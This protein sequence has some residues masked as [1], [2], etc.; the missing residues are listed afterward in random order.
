MLDIPNSQNPYV[1]K[2]LLLYFTTTLNAVHFSTKIYIYTFQSAYIYWRENL[3]LS[4]ILTMFNLL[5][6]TLS[7]SNWLLHLAEHKKSN[8][9]EYWV[10]KSAFY[11]LGDFFAVTSL[12]KPI[13]KA[14]EITFFG[15]IFM[16]L[17]LSWG[18]SI[19]CYLYILIMEDKYTQTKSGVMESAVHIIPE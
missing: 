5:S 9:T 2:I 15:W 13:L 12:Y 14:A 18:S 10:P 6:I 1:W 4:F 3:W 16:V 19:F 7:G 8:L 11:S 17:V